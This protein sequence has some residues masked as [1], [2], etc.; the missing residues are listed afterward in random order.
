VR[1]RSGMPLL[2]Y[3]LGLAKFLLLVGCIAF[4]VAHFLPQREADERS[5][6]E[7]AE[8]EAEVRQ[9]RELAAGEKRKTERLRYD[10]AYLEVVARDRLNLQKPGERVIRFNDG[11]QAE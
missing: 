3:L 4:G 11:Q 2:G 5:K 6:E 10:D 1:R 9:L 7:L 8:V